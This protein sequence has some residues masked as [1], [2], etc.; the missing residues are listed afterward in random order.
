MTTG[1]G[2]AW[3]D[4]AALIFTS[5]TTGYVSSHLSIAVS[6]SFVLRLPKAAIVPHGRINSAAYMWTKLNKLDS[7]VRN[8]SST[9]LF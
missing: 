5:G 8:D 1:S 2:V 3:K 7:Y 4:P 6:H 9:L